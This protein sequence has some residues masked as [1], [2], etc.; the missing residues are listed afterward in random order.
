M[1]LK[2][3]RK[4]KGF[5]LIE[6]LVVIMLIGIVLGISIPA[7]VNLQKSQNARKFE[8]FTTIVGE[9]ADLY[10]EQYGKSFDETENCFDIPYDSLVE[11]KLI[12]ESDITCLSTEGQ[13]G[14]IQATRVPGSN[15]Y[16]YQY[17]LTCTDYTTGE[18]LH[19]SGTA[20]TGCKGVNGNFIVN[21]DSALKIV[22]DVTSD[23]TF[24]S[25]TRGKVKITLSSV[26]PYFY[27]IDHYEYSLDGAD[28]IRMTGNQITFE[29]SMNS[30][31]YFRAI[32]TN[33][34]YSG[35][36]VV[37]I[38]IDNNAPSADIN[39]S[40]TKGNDNWY[41][42]NITATCKNETDGDG[43][44]IA[45]CTVN[46]TTI[47]QET[48]SATLTLTVK[49]NVGNSSTSSTTVKI[50]KTAPNPF[51]VILTKADGTAYTSGSRSNQDVNIAIT[52]QDNFSG[53][54]RYLYSS[55]DGSTW[56]SVPN[57][58][59]ITS[60][61]SYSFWVKAVDNAGNETTPA[62]FT[63]VITKNVQVNYNANGGSVNPT[64]KIV[65]YG[66]TY[67]TLPTPTRSGYKFEGWY[68]SA[69]GGSKVTS[70]TIVENNQTHT[71]YAHWTKQTYTLTFNANGGSVNPTSRSVAYDEVYGSLPTPTRTGYNFAGWYTSASGGS[72]VG[73]STKMGAGNTTIYAHWTKQYY[74]LY[75]DSNGGSSVGSRSIGYGD[76]YGS[77]PTPTRQGFSFAGWF[78]SA[79][80]GSQVSSSTKMGAGNTTIYAH[81]NGLP[82][83]TLN[84]SYGE[85]Q[86]QWV[87]GVPNYGEFTY[88][89][90]ATSGD[91]SNYPIIR[92]NLLCVNTSINVGGGDHRCAVEASYD[93]GR[94]TTIMS[95][96]SDSRNPSTH[97]DRLNRTYY[98]TAKYRYF[99]T[100][101][102]QISYHN[103]GAYIG[104]S[105]TLTASVS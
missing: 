54:N 84:F 71:L 93:G 29:I 27:D 36:T 73:S 21:I 89:I 26:N 1:Q 13:Q 40:G 37:K 57:N 24:D 67:G 103:S 18:T 6:L 99:R 48:K 33:G 66:N 12:Q 22:D 3:K 105:G 85:T 100:R 87:G 30:K 53:V 95:V 32:D 5:T 4:K 55:D 90:S 88:Y 41:T 31:V 104:M 50:D 25:W 58:W 9:A 8:Y 39:I 47:N 80:G 2:S 49:D 94:W 97:R 43:S 46:P 7:V 92:A 98:N 42:S 38:K 76:A 82:T 23:Y 44:G 10:V 69:S 59:K 101:Y 83:Q 11:E 16:T 56:Q 35:D 17:Y 74:T 51:S 14:I 72:Q 70:S 78:T 75:F 79:S 60:N 81:W 86:S 61:G 65:T 91:W 102:Y 52:A 62:K 19:Q 20:P 34:N 96:E 15:H 28:Y 68:T 45:S 63:I 77:L 64:S